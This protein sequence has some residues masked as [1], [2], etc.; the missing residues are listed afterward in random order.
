M[1]GLVFEKMSEEVMITRS[2]EEESRERQEE[3][4]ISSILED[5]TE[6]EDQEDD[7]GDVDKREIWEVTD[8]TEKDLEIR[9]VTGLWARP[10]IRHRSASG[11]VNHFTG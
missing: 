11:P 3:T 4:N 6:E 1:L 8:V 10:V 2:E 5:T 9:Y 7:E